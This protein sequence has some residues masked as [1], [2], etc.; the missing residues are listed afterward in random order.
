MYQ[1]GKSSFIDKGPGPVLYPWGERGGG[2]IGFN[3]LANLGMLLIET[4]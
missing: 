3:I 4:Y 1:L 2:E